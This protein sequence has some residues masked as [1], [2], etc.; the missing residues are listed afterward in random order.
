MQPL[1]EVSV[2][3]PWHWGIVIASAS[4][5]QLP[6]GM[7]TSLV[8]ANSHAV[9]VKVRHAQDVDL[10]A[11]EDDGDW[12]TAIVHVRS[13]TEFDQ[14][15]GRVLYDGSL[16]LPDGRLTVGDADHELVVNDLDPETLI[17]VRTLDVEATG[18]AEVWL[19]LCPASS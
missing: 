9:V 10:P 16:S 7:G 14:V 13:L 5:G 19:H 2:A 11:F 3:R 1:Y 17:R 6:D 15:V 8:V 4:T 18:L 12:M